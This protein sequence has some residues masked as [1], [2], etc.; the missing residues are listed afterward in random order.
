MRR[1]SP[2][3]DQDPSKQ[4]SRVRVFADSERIRRVTGVR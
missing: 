1:L 3:A 2:A 4:G